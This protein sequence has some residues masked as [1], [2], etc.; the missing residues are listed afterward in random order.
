MA[1]ELP[2]QRIC[3]LLRYDEETGDLYWKIDR[4]GAAKTGTVAGSLDKEGYTTVKIDKSIYKAHRVIYGLSYSLSSFEEI[5]HIDGNKSNN[6]LSNLR[7]VSRAVNQQNNK[8]RGTYQHRNCWQAVL[9][10]NGKKR[11]LGSFDTEE[12]AH[13]AYLAAKKIYHPEAKRN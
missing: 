10:A 8:V 2:L 7:A 11:Y 3:E 6:K 13:Q 5:D 9:K 4:T 1:K 12:E